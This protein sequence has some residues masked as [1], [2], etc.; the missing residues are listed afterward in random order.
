LAHS[1]IPPELGD[2]ILDFLDATNWP[3]HVTCDQWFSGLFPLY[4]AFENVEIRLF[5]TR[6]S[7]NQ[8]D[9]EHQAQISC[10]GD[11]IVT[12][13]K[14][15]ATA[16]QYAHHR[17]WETKKSGEEADEAKKRSF[18]DVLTVAWTKRGLVIHTEGWF[19]TV[20][21]DARKVDSA[22][23]WMALTELD[24]DAVVWDGRGVVCL[25]R[26]IL[27]LCFC[28]CFHFFLLL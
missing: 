5:V 19:R 9:E 7:T 18:E 3:D 10:L 27:L 6:P 8:T 23:Q 4:Q 15:L 13:M 16:F 20:W 12:R 24:S 14:A 21:I 2:L 26:C 22:W 25:P 11:A 1:Q 28:F 17:V